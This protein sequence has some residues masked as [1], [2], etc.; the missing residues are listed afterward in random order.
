M[1]AIGSIFLAT[2]FLAGAYM[3]VAEVEAVDWVLYGIC[4]GVMLVGLIVLRLARAV[5]IDE[6]G[7][8]HA[9]DIEVLRKSLASLTE[10]V[11]GFE[12]RTGD[13][14]QLTV[15]QRIDAE[16][17][18]DINDFVDARESMIPRLGMQSYADIMSPFANA[19]RLL[20][21]AWS[22]SADGYVDEVR[23][24]ITQARGE[25]ERAA[26]LLGQA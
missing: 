17:L 21:R 2:G 4:A 26:E 24:C 7:D 19:E 22:A 10:R 11:R 25:L 8:K 9:A 18:G 1:K 5:D 23:S 15:H 14:D 12:Q 13:E 20:N 16:L 6:A 3:T